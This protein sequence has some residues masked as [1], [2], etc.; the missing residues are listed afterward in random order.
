MNELRELAQG[1]VRLLAGALA[2]RA[3]VA[4]TQQHYYEPLAEAMAQLALCLRS[5]T[6]TFSELALNVYL[7]DSC[8]QEW[9]DNYTRFL[10]R[11]TQEEQAQLAAG[12]FIAELGELHRRLGQ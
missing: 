10:E 6:V 5:N 3:K 2:L 7:A 8:W 11:I 1:Y 12:D 9:H 4:P